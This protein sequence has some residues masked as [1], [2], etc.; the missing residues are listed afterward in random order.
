[1]TQKTSL[2]AL[3]QQNI[4]AM[5]RG[6][7]TTARDR[8]QSVLDSGQYEE[9]DYKPDHAVYAAAKAFCEVFERYAEDASEGES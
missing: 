1:M 5:E 8:L 7:I 4:K 9:R 2:D 3:V 6:V